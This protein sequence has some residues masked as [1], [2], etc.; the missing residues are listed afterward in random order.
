V[1]A[2]HFKIS[3]T[4]SP[5]GGTRLDFFCLGDGSHTAH[6][7]ELKRPGNSAGRK[8]LDQVRDYVYFLRE[9]LIDAP[10]DSAKKRTEI[11]GILICRKVRPGDIK[12]AQDYE[13]IGIRTWT[14]EDL[15]RSTLQMHRDFFDI[16]RNRAPSDDPRIAQLDEIEWEMGPVLGSGRKRKKTKG[17]LRKK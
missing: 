3:K 14:Y 16:V 4:R 7:V 2:K 17:R 11:S 9:K 1:I 6:V 5:E 8:E 10:I 15:L 13:K 12:L